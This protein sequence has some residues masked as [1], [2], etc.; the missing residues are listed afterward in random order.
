MKQ[1]M[2]NSQPS[3]NEMPRGSG[4]YNAE[5]SFA[6]QQDM[7][8]LAQLQQQRMMEQQMAQQQQRQGPG[9]FQRLVSR[10]AP[11]QQQMQQ[12]GPMMVQRAPMGVGMGQTSSRMGVWN[13]A[14]LRIPRENNILN[15][16]NVFNRQ[17]ETTIGVARRQQPQY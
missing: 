15:A 12:Q 11:G 13:G 10:F 14:S 9:T 8:M 16:P 1:R 17:G 7:D 5:D 3:A 4:Q 2:L 6:G